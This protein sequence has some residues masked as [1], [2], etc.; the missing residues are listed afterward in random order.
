MLIVFLSHLCLHKKSVQTT[1][2]AVLQGI[3]DHSLQFWF[4]LR[5]NTNQAVTACVNKQ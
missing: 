1:I 3:S 4:A 2:E 5:W